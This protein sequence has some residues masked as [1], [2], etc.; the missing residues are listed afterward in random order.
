[1]EYYY[2]FKFGRNQL[3]DFGG[4]IYNSDGFKRTVGTDPEHITLPIPTKGEIYYGTKQSPFT[5]D[6]DCYFETSLEGREIANWICNQGEQ[7]FQYID[8]DKYCNAVYN[9]KLEFSIYGG[10]IEDQS[11]VTIPFICYDG[12]WRI[13]E[14]PIVIEK[15]IINQKYNITGNNNIESFPTFKIVPSSSKVKFKWNDMYIALKDLKANTEYWLESECGDFYYLSAGS[16]VYSIPCLYTDE[17]YTMPSSKPFTT[18]VITLLEGS[19]SKL[20]IIKNSR[21]KE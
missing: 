15:P 5:F 6:L 12:F 3:S 11:I 2:D 1:M 14:V 21:I 7:R 8:D 17:Y 4:T 9:G 18:N 10:E 19:V 13:D 16:K 20:T